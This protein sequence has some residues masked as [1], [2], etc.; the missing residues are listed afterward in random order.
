M[1]TIEISENDVKSDELSTRHSEFKA[2]ADVE[3][4]MMCNCR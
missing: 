1:S 3:A 4:T 2:E